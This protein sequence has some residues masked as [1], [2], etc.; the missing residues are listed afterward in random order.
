[1]DLKWS[2]NVFFFSDLLNHQSSCQWTTWDYFQQICWVTT[3]GY[4]EQQLLETYQHNSC[5]ESNIDVSCTYKLSKLETTVWNSNSIFPSNGFW[6]FSKFFMILCL[7]VGSM[8]LT[9]TSS[10]SKTNRRA[11]R[12]NHTFV[13]RLCHYVSTHH[14]DWFTYVQPRTFRLSMETSRQGATSLSVWYDIENYH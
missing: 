4:F 12:Y 13:S 2:I 3:R 5:L 10:I 11:E 9:P 1:M 7:L 8:N 14:K 6:T